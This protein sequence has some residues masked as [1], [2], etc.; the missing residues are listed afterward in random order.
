M[1]IWSPHDRWRD[2]E[3]CDEG[4]PRGE[5]GPDDGQGARDHTESEHR[6]RQWIQEQQRLIDGTR[7]AEEG[8][9]VG[10]HD[11]DEQETADVSG[12][13]WPLP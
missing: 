1:E 4:E 5:D 11:A 6:R 7:A 13:P 12:I 2:Q 3:V 8:V 9:A 10:P